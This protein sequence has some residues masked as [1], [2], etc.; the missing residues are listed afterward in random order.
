[1]GVAFNLDSIRKNYGGRAVYS[2]TYFDGKYEITDVKEDIAARSV[3][4][5]NGKC[6]YNRVDKDIA[7]YTLINAKSSGT[8]AV[9]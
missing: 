2:K 9:R 1:M 4:L 8:T 3:F 7:C 5:K 6:I